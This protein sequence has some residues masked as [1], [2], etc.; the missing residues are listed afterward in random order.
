MVIMKRL[1]EAGRLLLVACIAVLVA[2]N[3]GAGSRPGTWEPSAD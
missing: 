2:T 3:A 1:I